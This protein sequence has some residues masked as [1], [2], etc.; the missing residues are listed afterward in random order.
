M[1]ALLMTYQMPT[2]RAF[3]DVSTYIFH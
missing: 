1:V 2:S 3:D